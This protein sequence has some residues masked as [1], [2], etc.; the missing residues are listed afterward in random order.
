MLVWLLEDPADEKTYRCAESEV[1]FFR[2]RGG[3]I[4]LIRL[5]ASKITSRNVL[6]KMV[7]CS[8]WKEEQWVDGELYTCGQGI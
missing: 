1:H 5:G 2:K 8:Q 3:C 6:P 4:G 7:K